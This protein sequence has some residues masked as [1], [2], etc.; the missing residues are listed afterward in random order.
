MR[1]PRASMHRTLKPVF[2]NTEH[3]PRP[4]LN[5]SALSFLRSSLSL[6]SS[7]QL[8]IVFHQLTSFVL[9][10]RTVV[11]TLDYGIAFDETSQLL[12]ITT[13]YQREYIIL[14]M[15]VYAPFGRVI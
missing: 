11:V 3:I 6:V 7:F 4:P 2:G 15:G 13:Y 8:S 9:V 5:P 10:L 1:I 14:V 12:L